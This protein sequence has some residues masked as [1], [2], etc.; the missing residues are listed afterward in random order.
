M[1]EFSVFEKN[2]RSHLP[3]NK[4]AR[5]LDFGC[6]TGLMLRFLHKK[7]YTNLHGADIDSTGWDDLKAVAQSL[8]KIDD[9]IAFLKSVEN[10]Y[11]FIIAKD[12]IYYFDRKII[13]RL[14]EALRSALL[15]GGTIYFEVFNGATLTGPYVQYKDL[16]IELILTEQSLTSLIRQSGLHLVCIKGNS[17]PITGPV[18]LLY[19]VANFCERLWL[20]WI[21]F[22][23]RSLDSQNPGILKRKVI[24]VASA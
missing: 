10:T 19:A 22:S 5:I 3:A 4:S 14:V 23:E 20:R 11:D 6:G 21:F 1:K 18:S 24:A 8:I 15:P 16:G 9:A 2:L 13:L 17:I 12:V 7:G